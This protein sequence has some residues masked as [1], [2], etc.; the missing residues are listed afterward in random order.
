MQ[1]H[2]PTTPASKED[3][4]RQS[5]NCAAIEEYYAAVGQA[6]EEDSSKS[7][8]ANAELMPQFNETRDCA[9]SASEKHSTEYPQIMLKV[10]DTCT[11]NEDESPWVIT[12]VPGVTW[13]DMREK[14][15]TL[16]LNHCLSQ[17]EYK[18]HL[19][20]SNK[21]LDDIDKV[22]DVSW[23]LNHMTER[24]DA[25]SAHSQRP[26]H[27]DR[28]GGAR[29]P[30]KRHSSHKPATSLMKRSTNDA[31]QLMKAKNRVSHKERRHSVGE[32]YK[33][34]EK[35]TA[36]P[37]KGSSMDEETGRSPPRPYL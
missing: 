17:E 24:E 19:L 22:P 34:S 29:A 33:W 35:S 27:H 23:A 21:N 31:K 32:G 4:E 18:S 15:P 12:A 8:K 20:Y 36:K 7:S 11:K 16:M 28:A 1:S 14:Q 26:S 10:A 37:T 30:R 2:L 6:L 25:G 9:T 3:L 5:L 13:D